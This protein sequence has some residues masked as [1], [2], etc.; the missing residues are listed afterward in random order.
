LSQE[1]VTAVVLGSVDLGESDRLVQL[2]TR[3]RGRVTARARGARK[4]RKRYGG[5]L[6]RYALVRVHLQIRKDRASMGEV[7][8]LRPFLGI[9]D[10][11]SR[12]AMADHLVE[13]LRIAT[14]EE[15]PSP[16]LFG[17]SV[18]ALEVLDSHPEP[19]GE[20]WLRAL[21]MA[22]LQ[23]LGLGVG[24]DRCCAC[25]GAVERYPAGFSPASGGVLCADHAPGEQGAARLTRIAHERLRGLASTDLADPASAPPVDRTLRSLLNRFVEYHLGRRLRTTA[26]LDTL[27]DEE[28]V[29][30]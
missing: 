11:L 10:D 6:D 2:L 24:V 27:L 22:V 17:L 16:S 18:R 30:G 1:T 8:L 26:F 23:E 15:E 4:S 7:D 28:A 3:E 9:R 12:T 29:Q 14:R 5:R 21:V 20:G 25:G 13:L 19:P